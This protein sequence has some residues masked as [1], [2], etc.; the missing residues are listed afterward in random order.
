[1]CEPRVHGSGLRGGRAP[2]CDLIPGAEVRITFFPF[3]R[4]GAERHG[5]TRQGERER[6]S[7]E[8]IVRERDADLGGTGGELSVVGCGKH[9]E[10][11]DVPEQRDPLPEAPL[12]AP[13]LA[14][15]REQVREQPVCRFLTGSECVTLPRF[16]PEELELVVA[17]G[18][19][20]APVVQQH[21]LQR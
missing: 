9:P 15:A 2:D 8:R 18:L 7:G 12:F 1:M 14:H 10:R 4:A 11:L 13:Q 16:Q 6:L 3:R 17:P 20:I 21:Y 19:E 5:F